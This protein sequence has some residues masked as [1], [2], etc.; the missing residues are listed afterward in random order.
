MLRSLIMIAG[1]GLA[2][3]F[4]VTMIV[5][6]VRIARHRPPLDAIRESVQLRVAGDDNGTLSWIA[7]LV[8]AGFG[9][10]IGLLLLG[11]GASNILVVMS[12]L[13]WDTTEGTLTDGPNQVVGS[14]RVVRYIID[15]ITY[16]TEGLTLPG[17]VF[18]AESGQSV[19]YDAT[20]QAAR[21]YY[22][23][24]NP[25]QAVLDLPAAQL[26]TVWSGLLLGAIGLPLLLLPLS[27][28]VAEARYLVPEAFTRRG[29]D[30]RIAPHRLENFW[31]IPSDGSHPFK[32]AIFDLVHAATVTPAKRFETGDDAFDRRFMLTSAAPA[33]VRKLF[34]A[35][36]DLRA[37]L[38]SLTGPVL[39]HVSS[40]KI[41]LYMSPKV[42]APERQRAIDFVRQLSDRL[43]QPD[44]DP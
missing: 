29:V 40:N 22:N 6:L 19:L 25:S 43:T 38:L 17:A 14:L 33:Q 34:A 36:D 42:D 8:G 20:G 15:D 9:V 21:V 39:L 11:L 16:E 35:H 26:N 18:A 7:G 32:G 23:P 4:G 5:S 30:L 12:S 3:A 44:G 37:K 27:L 10:V 31:V 24:N 41:E 1:Y 13:D 28:Y 2:L